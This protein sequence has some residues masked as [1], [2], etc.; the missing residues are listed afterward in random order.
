MTMRGAT[1]RSATPAAIARASAR[2]SRRW[3]GVA[4][5]PMPISNTSPI[6]ATTAAAATTPAS[7]RRR[8]NSASTS[9]A[10]SPSCAPRATRNTPGRRRSP[11][12]V[13]S[14]RAVVSV[15]DRG[16]HRGWCSRWPSRWSSP[17]ACC[18]RA[19]AHPGGFYA[20]IPWGVMAGVAARTFLF[21]LVALAIGA[22][23]FLARDRR[24]PGLRRRRAAPRPLHDVFTLRNLG[25]GGHGCN[26]RD[27]AF[28]MTRRRFHHAMFYGFLLCFAS[29]CVAT[30]YDHFLGHPAPYPFFS[31]PVLLGFVGGIRHAR[32]HGRA[33]LAQ[34]HR[35]SGAGRARCSGRRFRAALPAGAR[36]RHRPPAARLP[37]DRARWARCWRCISA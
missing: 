32:R 3:N 23:Q 7:T 36:R 31:P 8:T 25:G 5:S 10:P 11:R 37:R 17:R 1:W 16:R 20:V 6:S 4:P 12:A 21:A 27:E 2:C 18:S 34:D 28:S 19:H 30:F 15:R 22:A 14:Q 35:R 13:P 9:R 33:H 24:R 29:T 26:D